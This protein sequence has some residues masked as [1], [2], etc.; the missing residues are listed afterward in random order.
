MIYDEV[1]YEITILGDNN[2]PLGMK[3]LSSGEKQI[4]SLFAHLYLSDVSAYYVIIDEPELSLSV[5]WQKSFLPDIL[6]TGRCSFI[7]AVT[8][9][10]FIIDNELEKYTVDLQECIK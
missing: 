6:A 7:A 9:S 2:K 8:H 10:P 3:M 5:E 1:K 4:V